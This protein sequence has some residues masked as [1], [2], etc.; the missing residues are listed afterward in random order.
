MERWVI[1][2]LEDIHPTFCQS[3]YLFFYLSL[4]QPE[5]VEQDLYLTRPLLLASSAYI[6]LAV[7]ASSFTRLHKH[8]KAFFVLFFRKTECGNRLEQWHRQDDKWQDLTWCNP[9][10]PKIS[11]FF[12][13]DLFLK[14]LCNNCWHAHKYAGPNHAVTLTCGCRWL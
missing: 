1:S 5:W 7:R 11:S 9:K 12:L 6:F 4:L 3:F 14:T 2:S 13:G 8:T 10:Y